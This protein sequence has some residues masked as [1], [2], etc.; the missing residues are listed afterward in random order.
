MPV[1]ALVN[2][3][4]DIACRPLGVSESSW[5]DLVR[6][7]CN[8]SSPLTVVWSRRIADKSPSERCTSARIFCSSCRQRPSSDDRAWHVASRSRSRS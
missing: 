3:P 1:Q 5:R 2:R 6:A 7:G 8:T 4:R